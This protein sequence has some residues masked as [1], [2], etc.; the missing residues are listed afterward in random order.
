MN[1]ALKSRV[2]ILAAAVSVVALVGLSVP[3]GAGKLNGGLGGLGGT[4]GGAVGGVVGGTVGAAS[5]AVG[6]ATGAAGGTA[7]GVSGALGGTSSST[8]G[9]ADNTS[10]TNGLSG[11]RFSKK[12]LLNLKVNVLGIKA[13]IYALDRYGN[14]VRVHAKVLG[15]AGA[16]ARVYTLHNGNLVRVDAKVALAGLK[17]KGKVVVIDRHG[18]L[19]N[20]K[21]FIA[22]GGVKAKAGTKVGLNGADLNVAISISGK[23]PGTGGPGGPGGGQ[24]PGGT[25]NP[26]SISRE[27]S[28]LSPSERKTLKRKCPSV[29]ESPAAYNRDT[30]RVCRVL[31]ELAGN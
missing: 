11:T 23:R 28:S 24:G 17:V 30:V 3:A 31:A 13:G 10:T 6:A 7:S 1:T 22:L 26:G 15:L 5:G 21:A 16:K 4:V 12:A 19:L 29:L 2:G 9:V 8:Q 20:G 25:G 27:I 14:L 18:N